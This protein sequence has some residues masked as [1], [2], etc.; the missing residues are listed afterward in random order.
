MVFLWS[1]NASMRSH[2]QHHHANLVVSNISSTNSVDWLLDI[3]VNRHVTFDLA[4]L[5]GFE[6]Y[7]GN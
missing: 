1:F 6:P 4:T 5:T 2:G 7:L 3:G